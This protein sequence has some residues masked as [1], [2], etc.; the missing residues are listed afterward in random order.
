VKISLTKSLGLAAIS[1]II[2]YSVSLYSMLVPYA[3][4]IVATYVKY[5]FFLVLV[6]TFLFFVFVHKWAPQR[7][8]SWQML[9]GQ[10]PARTDRIKRLIAVTVLCPI[11]FGSMAFFMERWFAYPTRLFAEEEVAIN[12]NCVSKDVWGKASRNLVMIDAV[13]V[14]N[15]E[16]L[17]FPWPANQAPSCPGAIT[18]VGKAWLFGIYVTEIRTR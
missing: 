7:R 9:A 8:T 15:W 12:L 1:F 11:F 4:T 10:L 2:F 5:G 16:H 17:K 3:P 6:A 13:S 14:D 18:I